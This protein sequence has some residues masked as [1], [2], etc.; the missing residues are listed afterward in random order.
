M[1]DLQHELVHLRGQLST[2]QRASKNHEQNSKSTLN[3]LNYQNNS[4]LQE[5]DE[6]GL[7]ESFVF[8]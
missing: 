7:I 8:F 2:V 3:D 6:V 5:L 1:Q 4:L